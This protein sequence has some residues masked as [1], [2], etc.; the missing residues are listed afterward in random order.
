MLDG[1]TLIGGRNETAVRFAFDLVT[2]SGNRIGFR[3]FDD[4]GDAYGPLISP[5]V[6][7][8]GPMV[9]V[10]VATGPT[11]LRSYAGLVGTHAFPGVASSGGN[12]LVP[13]SGNATISIGSLNGGTLQ[14]VTAA[15]ARLSAYGVFPWAFSDAE[16]R[17]AIENPWQ[18]LTA[19]PPM[20]VVVGNLAALLPV[21]QDFSV[22]YF[23]RSQVDRDAQVTY[24]IREA[25]SAD[26]QVSYAI[27]SV[28]ERDGVVSYTLRST[29]SQDFLVTYSIGGAL[30]PVVQDFV[31]SYPIR[32]L[33]SA[34]RQVSYAIRSG[35]QRDSVVS[36]ILRSPVSQDYVVTYSIGLA[37]TPV[38]RDFPVS[39]VVRSIAQ[40]DSA[41]NYAI[42]ASLSSDNQVSYAIRTGVQRDAAVSYAVRSEVF[43]D[44]SA[45]YAI[46]SHVIR[47]FT[48]SYLIGDE[49]PNYATRVAVIPADGRTVV[50]TPRFN[51]NIV[52]PG[53][54]RRD[55]TR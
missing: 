34:D 35:V 41:V 6:P 9:V 28:V 45:T 15:G 4:N 3:R 38:V 16:A 10:G 39:Y 29:A 36:Y 19:G 8:D 51:D 23:V 7:D 14:Q 21:S 42:R 37:L 27:R 17:A 1:Q 22:D 44:V 52:G 13:M 18:L 47:D 46:R 48:I 53:G 25:V 30:S 54:R 31:V 11:S 2:G 49:L 40:Q 33:V 5:S 20:Q 24:P 50:I 55:V 26:R 32:S 12:T 43:R